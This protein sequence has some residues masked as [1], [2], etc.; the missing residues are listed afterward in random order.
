MYICTYLQTYVHTYIQ[1][2][3]IYIYLYIRTSQYIHYIFIYNSD[4]APKPTIK[5]ESTS[6]FGSVIS[7]FIPVGDA[8]RVDLNAH[9]IDDANKPYF[10]KDLNQWVVPGRVPKSKAPPPP[11]SIISAPNM[12]ITGTTTGGVGPSG[13]PGGG[14]SAPAPAPTT[15]VDALMQ[16][17]AYGR[18][19]SSISR[20]DNF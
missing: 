13:M 16:T 18:P 20:F 10:D 15:G 12:S 11:P 4:N 8:K 2:M 5:K 17:S 1:Y 7:S 3:Y 19:K 6:W 14:I 9:E